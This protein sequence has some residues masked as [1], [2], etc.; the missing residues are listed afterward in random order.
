MTLRDF[1]AISKNKLMLRL[2]ITYGGIRFFREV[3]AEEIEESEILD[4]EII[5]IF[6]TSDVTVGVLI[7][8][9]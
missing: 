5:E 8:P 4:S 3:Y 2:T 1:I 6:D 9:Q 7:K